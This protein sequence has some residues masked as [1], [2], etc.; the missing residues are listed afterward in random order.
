MVCGTPCARR[1]R[2]SG[3]CRKIRWKTRL[4]AVP[5]TLVRVPRGWIEA[6]SVRATFAPFVKMKKGSAR[7]V[8]VWRSK[9]KAT[10]RMSPSNASTSQPAI[11][12]ARNA[13][14]ALITL[15][16]LTAAVWFGSRPLLAANFLP[17][18]YCYVGNQRLLWTNVIADLVIG[19]SFVAISATLAWLVRRAGRDLPYSHFFWAFGVFIASCGGTHFME[20]LTVWKPVYCLSAAVNI[21]TAVASAGTAAALLLALADILEFARTARAA[22]AWRGNGHISPP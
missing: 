15:F 13:K 10:P 9:E 1:N 21:I 19:L 16:L 2:G 22:A 5:L 11:A 20:V 7:V 18:W 12:S 14:F 6:H 3:K 8:L 4:E 17:R